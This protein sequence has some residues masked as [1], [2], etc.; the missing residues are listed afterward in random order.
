MTPLADPAPEGCQVQAFS[1][2]REA[3]TKKFLRLQTS[4][5]AQP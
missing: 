1:T 2:P 3:N 4:L 5:P